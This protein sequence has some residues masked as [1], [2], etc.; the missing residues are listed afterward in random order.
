MNFEDSFESCVSRKS[1]PAYYEDNSIQVIK[2]DDRK[3]DIETVETF[4]KEQNEREQQFREKI[5]S[6]HKI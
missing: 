5:N 2:Y 4:Q 1:A 6:L 3:R